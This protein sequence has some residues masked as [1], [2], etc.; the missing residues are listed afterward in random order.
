MSGCL[1]G[2]SDLP[3]LPTAAAS[4]DA[5]HVYGGTMKTAQM[6]SVTPEEL[7]RPLDPETFTVERAR[8]LQ[9]AYRQAN[10]AAGYY[11]T[12]YR[13]HKVLAEDRGRRI[14]ALHEQVETLKARIDQLHSDMR[15]RSVAPFHFDDARDFVLNKA[16]DAIHKAFE[17]IEDWETFQS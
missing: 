16:T 2:T 10:D 17:L 6:D 9:D 3:G 1:C 15:A 12:K 14:N 4:V 7:L 8:Q 5:R 11:A 13:Q